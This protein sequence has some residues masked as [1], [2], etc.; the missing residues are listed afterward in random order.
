MRAVPLAAFAF[1]VTLSP[2]L[3]ALESSAEPSAREAQKASW[4]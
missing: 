1:A 2:Q 4:Q 3:S